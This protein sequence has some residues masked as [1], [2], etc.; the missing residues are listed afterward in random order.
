MIQIQS[1]SSCSIC[2]VSTSRG[3]MRAAPSGSCRLSP[4][5][6]TVSGSIVIDQRR[7]LGERLAR[8]VG[9]QH[10][11]ARGKGRALLEMQVGDDQA[12][13]RRASR[14]RRTCARR[15]PCRISKPAGRQSPQTRCVPASGA[16]CS[17]VPHRFPDQHVGGVAQIL[18][19]DPDRRP[20][21]GRSRAGSAPTS[22]ETR[23]KRLMPDSVLDAGKK[24]AETLDVRAA[25]SRRRPRRLR[26]ED[27]RD[28]GGAARRR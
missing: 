22:G 7:E 23:D 4:S 5:A 6:I 9:R 13:F 11:A 12:P 8:I 14:A 17:A 3:S 21:R 2:R 19:H 27:G 24:L 28:R 26:A 15:M 16:P 1:R 20:A 25:R 10:L 18:R